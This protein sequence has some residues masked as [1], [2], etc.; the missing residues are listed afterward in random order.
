MLRSTALVLALCFT[1]VTASA[2]LVGRSPATP[3]GTDYR[4][5]YDTALHITWVADAN[6]SG[7]SGFAAGGQMTWSQAQAWIASLNAATY[8]GANTWRL[9]V[10][11]QPDPSCSVEFAPGQYGGFGCT[12]SEMGHLSNADG[13]TSANPGP[14]SNVQ[15]TNYWSDTPYAPMAGSAWYFYFNVGG[16][17]HDVETLSFHAWAVAPGDPLGP[18]TDGDGIPDSLDNCTLV[19]NPSQLDADGDGYGNA[20]DAD[21]NNSGTVTAADFAILRSVLG[22]LATASPTAAAADLNGSGAVTAADFAILRSY[23]GKP[24]GPSGLHP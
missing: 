12:G 8:L 7:T 23:L 2:T 18:D 24:P 3:G 1:S 4:A 9:P 19:P 21:L 6:L 17:N 22:Q 16:Q 10:T 13:I 5:Y 14:F 15:L 11:P 20:C